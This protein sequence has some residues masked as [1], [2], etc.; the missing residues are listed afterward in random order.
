MQQS[1]KHFYP[2]LLMF[3]ALTAFFLAGGT[4]LSNWNMDPSVLLWGNAI[5]FA[6]TALSALVSLKGLRA[7]TGHAAVRSVYG[8]FMIKFFICVIA[9]FAYIMTAKKAVNKPA[10]F[11]C[12]GLYVVYTVL[13]VSI[14]T[15]LSR[16]RNG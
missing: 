15:K 2:V 3:I 12:M 6:A 8:S 5:L 1:W 7:K 13:E 14:L 4:L 11:T 9:A 16:Q 10:L